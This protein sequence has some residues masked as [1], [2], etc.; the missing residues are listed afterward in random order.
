MHSHLEHMYSLKLALL[1]SHARLMSMMQELSEI[2]AQRHRFSLVSLGELSYKQ[3][4]CHVIPPVQFSGRL[5][6]LA[7][8]KTQCGALHAGVWHSQAIRLWV[9]YYGAIESVYG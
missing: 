6:T 1:E 8:L 7:L 3:K 4:R 2:E 5:S 9:I